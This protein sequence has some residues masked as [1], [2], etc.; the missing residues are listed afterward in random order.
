MSPL[1]LIGYCGLM[2]RMSYR[3]MMGRATIAHAMRAVHMKC[4]Q[5]FVF[6]TGDD[7]HSS[8]A[9]LQSNTP[10]MN[11]PAENVPLMDDMDGS[12]IKSPSQTADVT[13]RQQEDKPS[14]LSPAGCHQPAQASAASSSTTSTGNAAVQE[15]RFLQAPKQKPKG[16]VQPSKSGNRKHPGKIKLSHSNCS[17]ASSPNIP[18]IPDHY[19]TM[20]HL[21][22]NRYAAL[23]DINFWAAEWWWL[24]IF[25]CTTVMSK[26]STIVVIKHVFSI[27]C[28]HGHL[29]PVITSN[30]TAD[31]QTCSWS[32]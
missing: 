6:C 2:H 10:V 26:T 32:A 19:L 3:G 13:Y 23:S 27:H 21:S 25:L 12:K 14:H 11:S 9:S 16:D 17:A 24:I 20:P 30:L 29:K 8:K 4:F 31:V 28:P 22:R 1:I 5:L 7:P 18:K 15:A